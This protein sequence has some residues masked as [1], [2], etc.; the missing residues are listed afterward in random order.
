MSDDSRN[1]LVSKSAVDD[2]GSG[3]HAEWL[4]VNW[5]KYLKHIEIE[6]RSVN[7][8]DFGKANDDVTP[9][10]FIH[11]LG[12]CWQNWLENIPYFARN[13]RV[14]AIDLPG[15]G[16]SQMPKEE[17]TIHGFSSFL[18]AFCE[19][20]GLDQI[21]LVGNSMGG[22]VSANYSS[23]YVSR[24]R[25]LVL[26]SPAGAY[27]TRIGRL[28]MLP[29]EQVNKR[30]RTL[31]SRFSKEVVRRKRA[32]WLILN[33]VVR[34]PNRIRPE[35]LYEMSFG[36][37]SPGFWSAMNAMLSHGNGTE[38]EK[39]EAPT[40]IVWGKSDKIVPVRCAEIF[41]KQIPISQ[42][43]I[44]EKTGHVAMLER[45]ARFNRLLDEFLSASLPANQ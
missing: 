44:F 25:R 40:L 15:F 9:L 38:L 39:I 18:D 3:P 2:Y 28:P 20:L 14:L 16:S 43:V 13:G 6:G 41:E 26:C 42:K 21:D 35:L 19:R 22:L 34:Y 36:F 7:Y 23:N 1:R 11:G 8:I 37:G 12:G 27:A 17:I 5:R 10:L 31:A 29:G 4:T 30:L 45:P 32:R 33:G 24:V